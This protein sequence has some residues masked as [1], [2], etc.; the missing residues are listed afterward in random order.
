MFLVLSPAVPVVYLSF[1]CTSFCK[2]ESSGDLKDLLEHDDPFLSLRILA[3][4]VLQLVSVF[5]YRKVKNKHTS[6]TIFTCELYGML[7]LL[8]VQMTSGLEH[9]ALLSKQKQLN[10]D[11]CV[12]KIVAPE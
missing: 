10:S 8:C 2:D 7:V 3:A 6:D 12:C 9:A 1:F 11:V 4:H 5:F